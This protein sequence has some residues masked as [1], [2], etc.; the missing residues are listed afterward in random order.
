MEWDKY[1]KYA[2]FAVRLGLSLVL[3]WFGID[4]L[5]HPGVWASLVPSWLTSLLHVSDLTFMRFNGVF[6]LLLALLLLIGWFTRIVAAIVVLHFAGIIY[7]VGYGDIAIRDLGLL[8]AALSLV[9]SGAG[10]GSVDNH[11]NV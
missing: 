9:L 7:A 2:P 6:E 3:L 8:L 11:K 5:R 4:E 10:W 1:A